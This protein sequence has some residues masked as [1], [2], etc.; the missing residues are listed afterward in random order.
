MEKNVV[1]EQPG[2]CLEQDRGLDLK[3][4][5]KQGNARKEAE[6]AATESNQDF[7]NS[8]ELWLI[9]FRFRPVKAGGGADSLRSSGVSAGPSSA[10]RCCSVV[11]A[12]SPLPPPPPPPPPCK[13]GS[14]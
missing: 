2:E 11:A 1:N 13:M 3:A 4:D 5:R 14:L 10:E 12:P 9:A 8:P 7:L 6:M